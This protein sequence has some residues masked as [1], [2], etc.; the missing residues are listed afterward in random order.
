MNSINYYFNKIMHDSNMV[1]SID[2]YSLHKNEETNRYHLTAPIKHNAVLIPSTKAAY[3]A[4]DREYLF[5]GQMTL[6]KDIAPEYLRGAYFKRNNERT[7][8]NY[9]I[10]SVIP[11]SMAMDLYSTIYA[12]KCT[13][14]VSVQYALNKNN[15]W[16]T[17]AQCM[18]YANIETRSPKST[19]DGASDD[20]I[21][22]M[23][24]PATFKI[25]ADR[26][27]IIRKS[28]VDNQIK[29]VSYKI[30]N[31][32]DSLSEYE[33]EQNE[34]LGSVKCQLTRETREVVEEIWI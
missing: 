12:A 2:I 32:D 16:R 30:L 3:N 17:I 26:M 13:M 8:N 22:T 33:L 1:E 9:L 20:A 23:Y 14:S 27:R 6:P 28:V 5:R 11:D 21:Y 18:V 15:D 29:M 19:Q 34:I 10:L 31:V 25:S 4:I 24:L 7:N